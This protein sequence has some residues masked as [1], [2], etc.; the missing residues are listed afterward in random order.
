MLVPMLVFE[1]ESEQDLLE[2]WLRQKSTKSCTDSDSNK[3]I[4][5][6]HHVDA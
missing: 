4:G 3:S 5:T 2:C 6:S 1:T